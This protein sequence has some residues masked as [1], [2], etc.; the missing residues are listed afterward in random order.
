M[1]LGFIGFGELGYE[2]AKGFQD[3][4]LRD[5]VAFDPAID[6]PEYRALIRQRAAAAGVALLAAPAEVAAC[7]D[8]IIAATPGGNALQAAA[9]VAGALRANQLYADF[10]S[11]SPATKRKIAALLAPSGAGFVDGGVMGA[12]RMLQHKVPILVSGS[13]SDRFIASMRPYHMS[14]EK[15]SDTAGDAVAIK[16]VRSIYTKGIITLHI[17]MMEAAV[18]LGVENEVHASLAKSLDGR[19]F[20]QMLNYFITSGAIHA[21]RQAHEMQDCMTMLKDLA[22][23]P[24]MTEATVL[25][26]KRMA[27]KNLKETFQGEVPASWQ[28]VVSKWGEAAH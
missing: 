3:E 27:E 26:L 18:A 21:D 4:G 2:M 16:L 14:L 7:A 6:A 25:R 1:R 5:S 20:M 24:I 28:E 10:S 12:L 9:A 17:E 15:V 13:G 11:S 23:A 19:S 22:I 8:V